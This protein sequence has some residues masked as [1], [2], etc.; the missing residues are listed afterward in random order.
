MDMPCQSSSGRLRRLTASNRCAAP[1]HQIDRLSRISANGRPIPAPYRTSGIRPLQT[2]QE[3]SA[4]PHVA[5]FHSQSTSV[6]VPWNLRS[7]LR[8]VRKGGL[9]VGESHGSGRVPSDGVEHLFGH[10][11]AESRSL[12]RMPPSVIEAIAQDRNAETPEPRSGR[13]RVRPLRFNA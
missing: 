9:A 1:S 7:N 3:H 13:T 4:I 12:E 2:A 5:I 8:L 6:L 11:A 10:A